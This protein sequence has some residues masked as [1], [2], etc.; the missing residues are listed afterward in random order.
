[1][2]RKAYLIQAKPGM[3]QEYIR[4]HNPV[5]PEIRE[6]LKEH[7]VLNFTTF[8]HEESNQLF[9]YV[10]IENEELFNQQGEKEICKKWWKYMAEVLVCDSPD[11]EKGK[12][13]ELKEIFHVFE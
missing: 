12:E 1:M 11:A 7:G 5:W 13:T 6:L 10:E 8:L 2:I 9:C 3:A 4:R